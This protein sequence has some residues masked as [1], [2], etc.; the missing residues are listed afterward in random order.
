[1]VRAR[2]CLGA[3]YYILQLL[4]AKKDFYVYRRNGRTGTSGQ[5]QLDGP[6]PLAEATDK[7]QKLFKQKTGQIWDNRDSNH[8]PANAKLYTYL[9]STSR[10]AGEGTWE[11][12]LTR[13]PMGKPDGWYPY[14]A[15]ASD[16]VEELYQTFEVDENA[17][18]SVRYV[19]SAT[20]GYT[21]RVDLSDYT[22]TNTT[23][24]KARTIRRVDE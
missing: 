7:F 23:S 24:G 19:A 13:D 18:M 21:Y 14:D 16:E 8:S 20:S 10:T 4:Q 3:R 22:Q 1:M 17:G 6:F 12:H 9:N 2:V 15:P 5:A 11:Y